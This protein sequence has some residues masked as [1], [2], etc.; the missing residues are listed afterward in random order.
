MQ[1]ISLF[2][3]AHAIGLA[4]YEAAGYKFLSIG[5]EAGFGRFMCDLCGSMLGGDR[6]YIQAVINGEH[7]P[8]AGRACVDCTLYMA[9]GDEPEEWDA[10]ECDHGEI[11][12]AAT[13]KRGARIISIRGECDEGDEG[14]RHTGPLAVGTVDAVLPN[15]EECYSVAFDN[16]TSVF[17]APAEIADP[18]DYRIIGQGETVEAVLAELKR[19]RRAK[20][21]AVGT[22]HALAHRITQLDKA[23]QSPADAALLSALAEIVI[24]APLIAELCEEFKRDSRGR[25]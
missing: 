15:M 13:L 16:G 7:V 12:D 11:M 25:I 4:E 9:N 2:A 10:S 17:L 21:G 20:L 18:A 1:T 3:R 19:E 23:G 24:N 22:L 8:D 14:E 6:H 5:D